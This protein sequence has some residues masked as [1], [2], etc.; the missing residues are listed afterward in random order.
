MIA[1][2]RTHLP[3][4]ADRAWQALL[5]RR[6]FLYITRGLVG[7]SGIEKWPEI[8]G[9]EGLEIETRIW[10][11]HIVPAWK[12]RLRVVKVDETGRQIFSEEQGGFIKTWNHR[13]SV[14]PESEQRCRYQDQI[15]IN[16]GWLT[17]C[18]WIYAHLFYR[19]RQ[20]RWR[21]LARTL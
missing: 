16:A 6:T 13:L 15:E 1:T 2:I 9:Q 7:F 20:M 14:E 11:F 3:T 19:Y 21:K 4:S 17:L 12:H 5:K 18:V 8:L 10:F